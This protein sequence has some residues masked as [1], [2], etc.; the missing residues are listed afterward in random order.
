MKT[1]FLKCCAE[2]IE[3]IWLSFGGSMNIISYTGSCPKCKHFIGLTQTSIEEANN[4][5]NKMKENVK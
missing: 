1:D 5:L 4:F 3:R 2:E